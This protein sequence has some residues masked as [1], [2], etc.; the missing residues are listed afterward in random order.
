MNIIT[1]A[2]TKLSYIPVGDRL[3]MLDTDLEVC[4]HTDEG[5]LEYSLLEGFV[6]NFRSPGGLAGDLI[7]IFIPGIGNEGIAVSWCVHDAGYQSMTDGQHPVSRC[8]ADDLLH[9][10]LRRYGMSDAKAWSVYEAVRH[11]GE[12]AYDAPTEWGNSGKIRFSWG[13]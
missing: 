7:D 6:T 10:M 13:A 8:I 1:A 2:H 9:Q 3:W 5:C 11:F 12:P 4:L